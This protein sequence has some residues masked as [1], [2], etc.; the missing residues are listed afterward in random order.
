MESEGKA[1]RQQLAAFYQAES[2]QPPPGV[3]LTGYT[4]AGELVQDEAAAVRQVFGRFHVGDSLRGVV[5]WL[6][7][8]GVATRSGRPWNPS[9]VR[10]IPADPRYAGRVVYRG[11]YRGEV[12]GKAA[13]GR[14]WSRNSCSTRCGGHAG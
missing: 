13:R 12:T 14:R 11:H 4:S 5:A 3:R 7:A 6:T 2:G 8:Q 9:S 10:T 1:E